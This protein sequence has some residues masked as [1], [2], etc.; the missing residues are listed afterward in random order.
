M[1]LTVL[2]CQVEDHWSDSPGMTFSVPMFTSLW[3]GWIDRGGYGL[4]QG[5]G[6]SIRSLVQVVSA[7]AL[8]D[9]QGTPFIQGHQA[10]ICLWAGCNWCITAGGGT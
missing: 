6:L 1:K 9:K 8:T 3:W 10:K 5:V 2:D 4:C 7:P